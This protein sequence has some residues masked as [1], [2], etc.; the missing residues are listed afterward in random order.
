MKRI[1]PALIFILCLTLGACTSGGTLGESASFLC[2]DAQSC[3][4]VGDKLILARRG[5]VKCLDLEGNEVF[6]SALSQ[7]DA[8]VSAS[9]AGAIAYCVGGNTVVF[10]DAETLTT[11]NAIVSASLSDCGM[12]AVCTFE[13]GYKGAVT[14]YS[15]E[16][17]AVYKWYSAL[18]EVTC[19]QVSPDG[20]QLAV[21]AENKLHLLCLDGKSAQ[22][23]YDCPEELRAIAWLDGAVCGIGSGGVYFLS[24]DGAESLEHSFGD[25]ITGKYGVL[26]GRLIIEVREDEKS[27]VCILSED[28]EPETEI[29]LRGSV[30]GMDCSDGRIL[31]LTHDSIGVYDRKGR[32]VSTGD[33]S[34]VSEAM[35]LDGG[36]VVTVGGG[37]A[38]ILQN[39]R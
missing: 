38:K 19:A 16:K 29:K 26:D 35:L 21:C 5:G 7:L 11:D 39:D 13:P 36:R 31:I 20:G 23:E 6:D 1:L 4:V 3:A 9:A 17:I 25:G 27:R 8:A 28:A 24:S 37:T 30:L 10:D 18:G 34:G 22:G 33:A 15:A 12:A 2:P 14:V 32:L